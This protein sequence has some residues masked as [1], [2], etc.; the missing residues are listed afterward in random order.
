MRS[1]AERFFPHAGHLEG[2]E[3]IDWPLGNL[4]MQTFRKLPTARPTRIAK[5]SQRSIIN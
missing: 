1:G 5:T 4:Y 3:T 2:G